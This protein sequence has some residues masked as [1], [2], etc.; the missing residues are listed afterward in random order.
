MYTVR[1]VVFL[2]CALLLLLLSLRELTSI[3]AELASAS[4][5]FHSNPFLAVDISLQQQQQQHY[6][7]GGGFVAAAA[8]KSS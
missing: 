5:M 4:S 8:A 6:D 2:M 3:R 1:I 7:D